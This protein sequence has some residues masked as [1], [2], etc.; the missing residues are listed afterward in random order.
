MGEGLGVRINHDKLTAVL[1]RQGSACPGDFSEHNDVEALLWYIPNGT[2][3]P[4]NPNA[5]GQVCWEEG[6][7]VMRLPV[8]L[9]LWHLLPL[10]MG[11]PRG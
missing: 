5:L 1:G 8:L 9:P 10:N 3:S 11:W 4:A 2:A 7:V 6:P